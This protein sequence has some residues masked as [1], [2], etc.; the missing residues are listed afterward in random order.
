MKLKLIRKHRQGGSLVPKFQT[1]GNPSSFGNAVNVQR[2]A[3]PTKGVRPKDKEVEKM[4]E[5]LYKTGYLKNPGDVDGYMGPKTRAAIEAHNAKELNYFIDGKRVY[6]AAVVKGQRRSKP[7]EMKAVS[8]PATGLSQGSTSPQVGTIENY[9]GSIG[10][11]NGSPLIYGYSRQIGGIRPVSQ[12]EKDRFLERLSNSDTSWLWGSRRNT[13]QS[14]IYGP[15]SGSVSSSPAQDGYLAT[16]NGT[17]GA[18]D[19]QQETA[20][21]GPLR[22]GYVTIP[23]ENQPDPMRVQT[24]AVDHLNRHNQNPGNAVNEATGYMIDFYDKISRPVSYWKAQRAGTLGGRAGLLNEPIMMP[25]I[26]TITDKS[27]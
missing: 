14:N 24:N 1:G 4:Q 10:I 21:F 11:A 26:I 5:H 16:P 8:N 2:A 27:S 3:S 22:T 9:S 23:V 15:T 19:P 25:S 6:R 17:T 7:Q 12:E 13:A 20:A 18:W